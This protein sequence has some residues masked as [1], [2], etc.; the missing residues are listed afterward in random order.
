MSG[1]GSN[2]SVSNQLIQ[3]ASDDV[4][5]IRSVIRFILGNLHG[6]TDFQL[7]QTDLKN[8]GFVDLY[9]LHLLTDFV[10]TVMPIFFSR[11]VVNTI[12]FCIGDS[13]RSFFA[14]IFRRPSN[15]KNDRLR[16]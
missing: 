8:L 15:K 6:V 3:Q 12:Y 9:M 10:E 11:L 14:I 16:S 13:D 1:N 4:Q 5:K 7:Q 2:V